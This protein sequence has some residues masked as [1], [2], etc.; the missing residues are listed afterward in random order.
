MIAKQ[1]TMVIGGYQLMEKLGQGGMG[2]V[3]KAKQL[4]MERIVAV[5]ILPPKFSHDQQFVDRF[6][7]E[8]RL[9]GRLN[10]EN[11]VSAIDVGEDQGYHFIAMEFIEGT[12]V[13]GLLKKSGALPEKEA[14]QICRQVAKGLQG[15]HEQKLIH[16]DIKPDNIMIDKR[17]VVKVMDLGLARSTQDDT[18]LTQTGMAL[19]TPHYASPEQARGDKDI[20][21]RCDFYSLGATLYH[22]VTG[23][24]PYNGE[25][26]AV[27]MASHLMDDPVPAH[28]RAPEREIS[29]AASELIM[30]LMSKDREQ[31][32]K[33]AAEV[34]AL[35]EDA[36]AGTPPAGAG[37]AGMGGKR[38]TGRHAP[39]GQPGMK[40]GTRRGTGQFVPVDARR[41]VVVDRSAK[42]APRRGVD[43]PGGNGMN[44]VMVGAAVAGV[45][46]L[47]GFALMLGG[48]GEKPAPKRA[49]RLAVE[50]PAP[51]PKPA[52]QPAPIRPVPVATA[53]VPQPV[54]AQPPAEPPQGQTQPQDP[55]E[56][57]AKP[58]PQAPQ[59]VPPP[60]PQQIA[61]QPV[62]PAAP[63]PAPAAQASDS[64][65]LDAARAAYAPMRAQISDLLK[66]LKV[67]EAGALM[68]K[69][70]QD[71]KLAALKPELKED[72]ADIERLGKLLAQAEQNVPLRKGQPMR[73]KGNDSI[74]ND[75]RNGKVEVTVKERG[76]SLM[77]LE[78]MNKLGTQE[79]LA[80]FDA[81]PEL[82]ELDAQRAR[83][84]L[85]LAV[86]DL[87]AARPVLEKL[88]EDVRAR[89]ADQ[90]DALQKA[91][92]AAER[93]QA[94]AKAQDELKRELSQIDNAIKAKQF[95]PAQQRLDALKEKFTDPEVVAPF[96]SEWNRLGETLQA[97]IGKP[98]EDM[99]LVPA[100]DFLYGPE[101]E[102]R[103]LPAFMID[104]CEVSNKDYKLFVKWLIADGNIEEQD[105][106]LASVRHPESPRHAGLYIPRYM[107]ELGVFLESRVQAMTERKN[108]SDGPGG[109]REDHTMRRRF[110]GPGG[111][112]RTKELRYM[113]ENMHRFKDEFRMAMDQKVHED[114]RPVVDVNWHSAYSYATWLG[115]KLPT[116][117]QWEKAARGTDGRNMPTGKWN[118]R[119]D[120]KKFNGGN[121]YEFRD[122][123]NGPAPVNSMPEGASPFGVLH[124]SGNVW[125]WMREPGQTRGGSWQLCFGHLCLDNRGDTSKG[126]YARSIDQGFRCVKE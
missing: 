95:E 80:F 78:S 19:G 92:D 8:A 6:V 68:R 56:V 40:S 74:I 90:V 89:Y 63:K 107:P 28:E 36:I 27:I 110:D 102:K 81:K 97:A 12:T 34:I 71:P 115:K 101:R 15:A 7:R 72:S 11:I 43:A 38:R 53:P 103:S 17:G 82:P 73:F 100:G 59:P 123:F 62:E 47:G 76:Q 93:A 88:P 24:T 111:E 1:Q 121:Q 87:D 104:R 29:D 105:K 61:H 9:A 120:A 2:T 108:E 85:H 109:P 55:P 64:A 52:A 30:L 67:T 106:R 14:L 21:H 4:S 98:K 13:S 119:E 20:D 42:S 96:Q 25:T 50:E 84:V 116:P 75:L 77:L 99:V 83:A 70:Q 125:E 54:Q 39:V 51:A 112:D 57:A 86:Q 126:T 49:E 60:P 35:M 66:E 118:D 41:S 58:E 16:R 114:D 94:V 117:E 3:Y 48:S 124:L 113:L 91:R 18:S 5:K 122:E 31:R 65:A 69:A 79:I 23:F 10:H 26:A 37:G 22:M 44:P 46:L 32:P 45:V 33:D